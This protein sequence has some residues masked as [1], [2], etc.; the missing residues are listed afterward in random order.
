LTEFILNMDEPVTLITEKEPDPALLFSKI[1]GDSDYAVLYESMD[2]LGRRGRYSFLAGSP[3]AILRLLNNGTEVVSE[4]GSEFFE[5]DTYEIVREIV[6]SGK[7]IKNIK[8]FSGGA[9]GYIGYSAVQTFEKI[10]IEGGKREDFPRMM[11]FIPREII[12]IDHHKK[13]TQ[14]VVFGSDKRARDIIKIVK[15]CK[16]N[17]VELPA[18]SGI[19]L[20]LPEFRSLT[21]KEDFCKKVERAKKYILAGDIF[22]VVLSQQFEFDLKTEPVNLYKALRRT[23]P[24]PYLYY[25]QLKNFHVLGSSPEI[26]VEI[27]NK[28][29]VTRPLAGTRPRG[30]NPEED[31]KMQT[32]LMLDEK[33]KAEHIMLVD[34]ARNDLGRVCS[35]G[36]VNVDSIL[37]IEK[38][39]K[40][41]HLVSNVSGR[42]KHSCDSFDVVKSC[43]PAGTVSGAPKIRAMEIIDELETADRGVY[44]GAIGYF[45]FDGN[46]ETCIGIRMIVIK[47]GKGIV[48]AGA[49]IVADSIPEKEYEE[50]INK[51]RGV[52]QAVSLAGGMYD[53]GN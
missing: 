21:A 23:N 19:D 28:T 13:Q 34:L 48:Q 17:L 24:A 41:M 18:D 9:I 36:S 42:V 50:T 3:A 47:H 33:E 8:P 46:S 35:P 7:G 30:R 45:G 4:S 38:F 11:F 37:K 15:I 26:L 29:A 53:S 40:V 2:S 6:K 12:I 25:M 16:S 32:E 1:Y 5:R 22:Q 52:L 14:V 44:A 10:N 39:K 20:P 43:F 49:G 51:A 31:R 27:K